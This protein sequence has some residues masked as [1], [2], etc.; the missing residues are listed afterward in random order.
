MNIFKSDP[1][2]KKNF[3]GFSSDNFSKVKDDSF[4]FK[5]TEN[6]ADIE[7][8]KS[9]SV[10]FEGGI[11]QQ[12]TFRSEAGVNESEQR[13]IDSIE[14]RGDRYFKCEQVYVKNEINELY[15]EIE[16]ANI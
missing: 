7:Q 8:S 16:T 14:F 6:L 2:M 11:E 15:Q 10:Y 13:S 4:L 1:D 3:P 5:K 9:R 12:D